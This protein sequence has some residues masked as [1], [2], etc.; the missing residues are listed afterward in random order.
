[1]GDGLRT[2]L[3]IEPPSESQIPIEIRKKA[4][5]SILAY[6]AN[7]DSTRLRIAQRPVMHDA[8]EFFRRSDKG[9]ITL[10]TGVGKTVIF[11]E[12]IRET[13]LRALVVVPSRQLLEQTK[14]EIIRA[15]VDDVSIA[16]RFLPESRR[17]QVSIVTYAS[18]VR[19]ARNPSGRWMLDPNAY[20]LVIF[21]EAHHVL[22]AGASSAAGH[23]KKAFQIGFT[24]TPNYSELRQ[25][26]NLLPHKIHEMSI[27]ESIDAGLISPFANIVLATNAD[28][29]SVMRTQAGDYDARALEAAVNTKPRNESIADFLASTSK[30]QKTVVSCNGIDHAIDMAT[31]LRERGI[32]AAAVYGR[33]P[34]AE[35]ESILQGF[36]SGSITTITNSK[37][38]TEGFDDPTIEIIVNAAPTLSQVRQQQRTG[39]GLRID[40]ARPNKQVVIVDCLDTKYSELPVLFFDERIA[41][42]TGLNVISP[43]VATLL[44]EMRQHVPDG[45]ELYMDEAAIL[46][47]FKKAGVPKKAQTSRKQPDRLDL[48]S[49][50]HKTRELREPRE[51]TDKQKTL[52]ES[53][54]AVVQDVLDVG[55]LSDDEW[56]LDGLCRQTDP[57]VFYPEKGGTTL[58]AKK[59]CGSCPVSALCLARAILDGE[60]FGIWGMHSERERRSIRKNPDTL[61]EHL[62]KLVTLSGLVA[63]TS[64]ME[65][66]A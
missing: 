12:I 37:L 29:S 59:I 42:T 2:H 44:K 30:N 13:G 47:N 62:S 51:K 15:G 61:R 38:L 1:M 26:A 64:R 52:K 55:L 31:A 36:R 60:Y 65:K 45:M 19:Q 63:Q 16:S 10:P 4:Y 25:L 9:Y 24:A 40:P 22:A 33:M 14:A 7:I 32:A 50:E 54:R 17:G 6:T 27:T 66:L 41:G 57:E 46:A 5:D 3:N 20:E 11:S 48:L 43:R 39:R 35:L 28:M 21:D 58:V 8:A 18:L 53:V 49:S 23:Y 56:K 34:K